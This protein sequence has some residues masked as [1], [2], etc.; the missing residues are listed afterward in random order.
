MVA[1]DCTGNARVHTSQLTHFT[2]QHHQRSG[3]S[4]LIESV[5]NL[6]NRTLQHQYKCSLTLTSLLPL[7]FSLFPLL[8][9]LLPPFYYFP[10]SSLPS[11]T[12]PGPSLESIEEVMRVSSML[13]QG[14]WPMN[15]P[16]MQLPHLTLQ[17]LRHFRTKRVST[18]SDLP[19]YSCLST[20]VIETHTRN[21][22]N[23]AFSV[24]NTI[25]NSVPLY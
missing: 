21:D 1:A 12:E 4:S 22:W 10:F 14:M 6:K 13:V 11:S 19:F 5:D 17:Q 25:I 8:F 3:H 2:H 7:H 20:V 16:L 23:S 9:S 15:S 24:C 18:T